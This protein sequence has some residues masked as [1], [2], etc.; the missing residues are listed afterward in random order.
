MEGDGKKRKASEIAEDAGDSVEVAEVPVPQEEEVKTTVKCERLGQLEQRRRRADQ[1]LAREEATKKARAAD[2]AKA[3]ATAA[4]K[5]ADQAAKEAAVAATK[6]ANGSMTGTP[7]Q[8]CRR[9]GK[10]GKA[11]VKRVAVRTQA[12]V[13]GEAGGP[14]R[15]GLTPDEVFE[16]E[17]GFHWDRSRIFTPAGWR[18]VDLGYVRSMSGGSSFAM[19]RHCFST[20]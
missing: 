1:Q 2:E 3:I 8:H 18:G 6:L 14:E 20:L 10:Q 7:S 15:T 16:R 19:M 4:A 9:R 17:L 13:K 5:A 11:S 12:K